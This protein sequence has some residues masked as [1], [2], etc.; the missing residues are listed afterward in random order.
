M[1][2][3]RAHLLLLN[4]GWPWMMI[5]CPVCNWP[6]GRLITH[7]ITCNQFF[8]KVNNVLANFKNF[9]FTGLLIVVFISCMTY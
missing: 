8:L 7:G 6:P 9:I 3:T 2:T 5:M 4:V 1:L